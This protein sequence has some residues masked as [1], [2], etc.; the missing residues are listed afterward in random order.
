MKQITIFIFLL[1]SLVSV[2]AQ[3]LKKDSLFFTKIDTVWYENHIKT[4]SNG[5]VEQVLNDPLCGPL[6]ADGRPTRC[7]EEQLLANISAQVQNLYTEWAGYKAMAEVIKDRA[8]AM[9]RASVVFYAEVKQDPGAFIDY[10]N[11][12]LFELHSGLYRVKTK[13]INDIYELTNAK[14]TVVLVNVKDSE[15]F[16]D[17]VLTSQASFIIID[18]KAGEKHEVSVEEKDANGNIVLL[19]KSGYIKLTRLLNPETIDP[20]VAGEKQKD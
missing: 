15:T 3:T 7:N 10:Q 14:G 2:K 13:E 5:R 6:A 18:N 11:D 20:D 19:D 17:I 9:S 1:F 12:K 16:F 8:D 4:Y